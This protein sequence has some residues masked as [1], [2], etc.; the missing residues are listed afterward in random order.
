MSIQQLVPAPVEG[1]L[2]GFDE[3]MREVRGLR[4]LTRQCYVRQVRPFVVSLADSDEVVSLDSL[5]GAVVRDF[6]TALSERYSPESVKLIATSIRAFL[7]FAWV[8]GYLDRDLAPAVG[9]VVTRRSGKIP[10]ALAHGELDRLLQVPDRS[11][12]AGA[13]DYAI[14]VVL[15][16]LGLRAGEAAGLELDDFHWRA[17]TVSTGVKGGGRSLLPLP[18]EVAGAVVEY[19]QVRPVC[20]ARAV[21]LTVKGLVRA[22]TGGAITAM[23]ARHAARAGL[24]TVRAHRLRHTAARQILDAGGTLAEVGQLLGHRDPQV[25]M[26][27]ASFDLESLRALTQPWPMVVQP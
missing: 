24:G 20:D 15:S 8:R 27:Y 11:L 12:A 25:T 13:R 17:G 23:V 7:R 26:M 2:G 4:P 10:K 3:F 5:S 21:F 16:R 9:L 19:L 22:L 14:L 18:Q 1:L 6:V